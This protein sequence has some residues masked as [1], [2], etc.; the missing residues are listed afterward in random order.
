M[1]PVLT[2]TQ[3]TS[4]GKNR[5]Y[6]AVLADGESIIVKELLTD[7]PRNVR[8]QAALQVLAELGV[9]DVPRLLGTDN[10]A[11]LMEDV[12]A[13]ASLADR[14]LGSDQEAAAAAV[15]RWATAIGSL[16]AATLTA[17]QRFG[18]VLT[19]LAPADPPPLD[20]TGPHA[21]DATRILAEMLPRL[22]VPTDGLDEL[23][24]VADLG[25]G[26]RA[27]TPGDACPD[28]NLE[29]D[30]R[31]ILIDFEWSEYRH[32]AWDAAYLTVPWPTCWCSWRLPASV[33]AEAIATWRSVLTPALSP[34][35]VAGLDAAIERATVAWALIT[36][37]SQ[38]ERALD[39]DHG[40]A[41]HPDRPM[42]DRRAVVQ[43]RLG[44]AAKSAGAATSGLGRL[45]T[46]T[47]AATQERWGV[48]ELPLGPAWR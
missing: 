26:P 42:P 25:D 47:L 37:A 27:L 45:A 1:Q 35:Q 39:P 5:V 38:L 33:S 16:Q 7:G 20:S 10:G 19:T 44:L 15:N 32:V 6:R 12:G 11:I 24:T 48:L 40:K 46:A 2:W 14:L 13:G 4:S 34:E 23:V 30:G 18:D 36:T 21:R 17:G 9:E 43:H 29:R 3:L 41:N 22:G 8:E 28:N 31:Q